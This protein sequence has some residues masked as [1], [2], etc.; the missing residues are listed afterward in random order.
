MNLDGT[1]HRIPVPERGGGFVEKSHYLS[2]GIAWYPVGTED[3]R[4]DS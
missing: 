1:S 2:F 3:D 4:T